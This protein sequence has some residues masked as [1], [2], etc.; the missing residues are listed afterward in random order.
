MKPQPLW[1]CWIIYWSGRSTLRFFTSKRA[2]MQTLAL[3][4][5]SVINTKKKRS[6]QKWWCCLPVAEPGCWGGVTAGNEETRI[7]A[8]SLSGT[9]GTTVAVPFPVVPPPRVMLLLLALSSACRASKVELYVLNSVYRDET[10]GC[11]PLWEPFPIRTGAAPPTTVMLLLF[12]QAVLRLLLLLDFDLLRLLLLLLL[13]SCE[14][15]CC[16]WGCRCAGKLPVGVVIFFTFVESSEVGELKS[17]DS[18]D[19]EAKLKQQTEKEI[20]AGLYWVGGCV[21]QWRGRD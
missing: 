20:S 11:A 3:K 13:W 6:L 5:F 1:L 10:I 16:C 8:L 7:I 14:G 15:C 9:T 17:N 21:H 2:N 18:R 19:L 12:T 4:W